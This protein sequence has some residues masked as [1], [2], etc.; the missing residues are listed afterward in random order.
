MLYTNTVIVRHIHEYI[1]FTMD[2]MVVVSA[3]TFVTCTCICIIIKTR[4]VY[5]EGITQ[6]ASMLIISNVKYN[7]CMLL[8]CYFIFL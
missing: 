5:R 2:R 8:H 6:H 3:G 1:L 7:T 4:R